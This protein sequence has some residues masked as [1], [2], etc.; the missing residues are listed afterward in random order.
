MNIAV[1]IIHGIG[2]QGP[3]F[4]DGMMKML[5]KRFAKELGISGAESKL[6]L[7]IE[8]I[9]WAP[10]LQRPE[11]TLSRNVETKHT[12]RWMGFRRFMISFVADAVAYQPLPR[13]QDVYDDV[14][15]MLA[16][17]FKA[18]SERAGSQAPLACIGYSLGTVILSNYLYD[19]QQQKVRPAV[20]PSIGTT[21]LEQGKTLTAFY[22]MGSPIALWSL[23]YRDFGMPI[24]VPS[25]EL[26][27]YYP[28]L[29][30][31][32]L[33][34]FDADDVIGYPLGI[35][36]AH[37]RQRVIDIPVNVGGIFT[38]WNPLSHLYYWTD[39][40]VV[41]QIAQ[42]LARIWTGVN[43]PGD[44]SGSTLHA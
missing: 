40:A 21:P 41:G 37:Y 24:D 2:M 19:L 16:R 32:W 15:K 44:R 30:G 12:L 5:Y 38:S 10:V 34:F 22:T 7:C 35:L 17:K 26:H 14:H 27:S 13:E 33:N 6:R 8:P 43:S 11:D 29:R 9:Y 20:A 3:N 39:G 18:L 23:R 28:E 4:A 1:A 42:S 36:N 31:E 25:G